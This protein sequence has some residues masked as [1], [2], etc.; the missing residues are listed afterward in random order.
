MRVEVKELQ[1][2]G[3]GSEGCSFLHDK[4]LR[5]KAVASSIRL[6]LKVSERIKLSNACRRETT[7]GSHNQ[8]P[9]PEYKEDIIGRGNWSRIH[10]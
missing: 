9:Q 4:V 2:V 10:T 6:C 8:K 5:R 1:V 3:L 7:L